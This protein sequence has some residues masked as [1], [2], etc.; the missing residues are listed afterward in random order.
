[1]S[2]GGASPR[3][4]VRLTAEV[5]YAHR[6]GNGPSRPRESPGAYVDSGID[7]PTHAHS[8]R[9]AVKHPLPER[10]WLSVPA[11]RAVCGG[12]A[13]IYS[14]IWNASFLGFVFQD[15]PEGRP[16]LFRHFLGEQFR[17][18]HPRHVEVLNS[19]PV[20]GGH[21]PV[22]ETK[23]S[24]DRSFFFSAVRLGQS[25]GF[26]APGAGAFL[27]AGQFSLR[28]LD[29]GRVYFPGCYHLSVREGQAVRQ[30]DIYPH[31]IGGPYFGCVR[32]GVSDHD[33]YFRAEGR[34]A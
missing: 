33:V 10:H 20:V 13:G 31:G 25:E 34:A 26:L 15:V 12:V 3:G 19:Y 17:F 21:Q 2:A 23:I 27:G 11:G 24:L 4:G 9:T 14:L 32:F 1:M 16:S 7:V 8:T 5:C 6:V 18:E 29:T 28:P 22:G 30:T